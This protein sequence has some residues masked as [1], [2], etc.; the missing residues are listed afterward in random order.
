M[1]TQVQQATLEEDEHMGNNINMRSN[2][3]EHKDKEVNLRAP[4]QTMENMRITKMK[5]TNGNTRGRQV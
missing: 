4:L 3:E 5:I 2:L 1:Q